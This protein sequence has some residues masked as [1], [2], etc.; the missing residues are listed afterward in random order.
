MGVKRVLAVPS[1]R[2][3]NPSVKDAED[4]SLSTEDLEVIYKVNVKMLNP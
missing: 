2:G 1:E 3:D 4:Y